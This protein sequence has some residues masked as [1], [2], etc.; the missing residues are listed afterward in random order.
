MVGFKELKDKLK[1][2]EKLKI[3][4]C[5]I[6]S[7]QEAVDLARKLGFSVSLN[8]IENDIELSEDLLEAIAGGKGGTKKQNNTFY[9]VEASGYDLV[10]DK[11]TGEIISSKQNN[12]K[13]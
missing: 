13:G 9:H 2:D 5:G 10:I 4:F 12:Y 11:K 1:T 6:K 7:A 3:K 8:D